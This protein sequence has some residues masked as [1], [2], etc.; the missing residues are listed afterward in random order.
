MFISEYSNVFFMNIIFFY[1]NISLLLL[2]S[3]FLQKKTFLSVCYDIKIFHYF[4]YL[5]KIKVRATHSTVG[6]L[7][8]FM[9]TLAVLKINAK[10]KRII[11]CFSSPFHEHKKPHPIT[12]KIWIEK[13]RKSGYSGVTCPYEVISLQG[14]SKHYQT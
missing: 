13:K 12:F 2:F 4:S 3:Y 10:L 11:L 6:Y 7:R 9:F 1:Q 8:G 5:H 14:F